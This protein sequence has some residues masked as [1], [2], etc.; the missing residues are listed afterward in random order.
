MS[1][2]NSGW[3]DDEC[4]GRIS[5]FIGDIQTHG[6]QTILRTSLSR[7]PM[8]TRIGR[9]GVLI[10]CVNLV[11]NADGKLSERELALCDQ[12]RKSAGIAT[13]KDTEQ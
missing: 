6:Y 9:E 1:K 4:E 2:V 13:S 8:F 5:T 11:A 3:S 10:K 7:I 12:I